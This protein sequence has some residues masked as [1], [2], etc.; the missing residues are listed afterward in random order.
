MPSTKRALADLYR[1]LGRTEQAMAADYQAEQLAR[2]YGQDGKGK[3]HDRRPHADE[4]ARASRKLY[5]KGKASPVETM[6]AVLARA[7]KV[8]PTHQ[9]ALP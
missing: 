8:N 3:P 2:Q 1:K 4:R 5:A 6:K 7:E 9:R